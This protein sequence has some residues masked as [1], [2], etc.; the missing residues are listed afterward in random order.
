MDNGMDMRHGYTVRILMQVYIS[1][2]CSKDI[3]CRME[4]K[5]V[6]SAGKYSMEYSM[7][8]QHGEAAWMHLGRAALK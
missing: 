2:T 8:M 6:D 5:H 7:H 4:M 3:G 1:K